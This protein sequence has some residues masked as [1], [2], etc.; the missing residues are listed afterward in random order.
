MNPYRVTATVFTLHEYLTLVEWK[1]RFFSQLQMVVDLL[2]S[3][4]VDIFTILCFG[5]LALNI[6]EGYTTLYYST[7]RPWVTPKVIHTDQSNCSMCHRSM[8]VIRVFVMT[9]SNVD[10]ML[11]NGRQ[12]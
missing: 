6:Q 3:S 12:C 2:Q 7:N 10:I 9:P 4:I 1:G 5:L 11:Q 8:M